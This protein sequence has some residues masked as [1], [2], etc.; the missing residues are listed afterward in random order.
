MP[1]VTKPLARSSRLLRLGYMPVSLNQL[2]G[3]G[4]PC[5]G[6]VYLAIA[7]YHWSRLVGEEDS[8]RRAAGDILTALVLAIVC[9]AFLDLIVR[10]GW[11]MTG[12]AVGEAG[13]LAMDFLIRVCLSWML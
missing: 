13:S 6:P 3:S 11:W 9:G 1:R 5:S 2:A 4:S 7:V 12:A 10:L 8:A